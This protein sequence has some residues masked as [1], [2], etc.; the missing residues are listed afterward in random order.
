MT[1]MTKK[2]TFL[3]QPADDHGTNWRTKTTKRTR[4]TSPSTHP[5]PWE[6]MR[7]L[8]RSRTLSNIMSLVL[9]PVARKAQ[10]QRR[11]KGLPQQV[12]FGPGLASAPTPVHL[13]LPLHHQRREN[14]QHLTLEEPKQLG[15]PREEEEEQHEGKGDSLQAATPTSTSAAKL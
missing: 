14:Q 10:H 13:P 1:R 7:C 4:T 12:T 15:E 3:H 2:K 5:N 11:E 6:N 8:S 9:C